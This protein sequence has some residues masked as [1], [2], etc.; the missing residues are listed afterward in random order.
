MI[1]DSWNK[2]LI[3]GPSI[4][5]DQGRLDYLV[6]VSDPRQSD[7]CAYSVNGESCLTFALPACL[8]PPLRQVFAIVFPESQRAEASHVCRLFELAGA[9][10]R[11][12][13]AGALVHA[14]STYIHRL[15][16]VPNGFEF[17]AQIDD[18]TERAGKARGD[19][20]NASD[21]RLASASNRQVV[22]K[23][24]R[25]LPKVC[26]SLSRRRRRK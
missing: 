10:K 21:F 25:T 18:R 6:E 3:A 8:T 5:P 15:R 23:A 13:V 14:D 4:R 11:P 12:L 16:R 7:D 1:V 20:S 19:S 17:R 26:R 9:S 2:R 24:G 22:K